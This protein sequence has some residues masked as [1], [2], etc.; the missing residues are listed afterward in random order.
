MGY[1][2]RGDE[3]LSPNGYLMTK[4]PSM[5][6]RQAY[7]WKLGAPQF[8]NHFEV[9]EHERGVRM[10]FERSQIKMA[11][12]MLKMMPPGPPPV[13]ELVALMASDP[14]MVDVTMPSATDLTGPPP[15]PPPGSGGPRC[16]H[17]RRRQ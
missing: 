2:R 10:E 7:Y 15:P 13:G 3:L 9:A 12:S 1:Q 4:F 17:R 8:M 14:S 11:R 16:H 6:E 5:Q